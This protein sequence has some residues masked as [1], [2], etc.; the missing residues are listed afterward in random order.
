MNLVKLVPLVGGMIDG[1]IDVA[2]TKTIAKV[3]YD[4][5]I[6]GQVS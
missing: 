5:F 3:A 1:G 6:E 4:M 2:G